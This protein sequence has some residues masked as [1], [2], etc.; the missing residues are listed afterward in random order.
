MAAYTSIYNTPPTGTNYLIGDTVTLTGGDIWKY[1]G[2]GQWA[3]STGGS[4]FEPITAS[5]TLDASDAGQYMICSSGSAIVLAVPTDA[6]A[7]WA[8]AV[9]IACYRG[10][11]GAVTFA[12]ADGV[13]IRGELATPAQYGSKG[14]V[15]VG[16][17]EWA[18]IA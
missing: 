5:K 13:T 6:T 4:Q 11:V 2:N 3:P 8:G 9:T 15:R 12:A 16:A 18:V 10:G 7:N 1:A 17:N 14:I